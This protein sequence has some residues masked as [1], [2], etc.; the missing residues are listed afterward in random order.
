MLRIYLEYLI[1]IQ[2][3]E[4]V[5]VLMKLKISDVFIRKSPFALTLRQITLVY[6]CTSYVLRPQINAVHPSKFIS[7]K[8]PL[9]FRIFIQFL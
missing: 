5:N 7:S 3:V 4:N 6:T 8:L 9:T 2:S 1:I